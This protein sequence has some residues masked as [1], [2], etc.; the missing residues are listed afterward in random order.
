M[1]PY[2]ILLLLILLFD[3]LY[4]QPVSTLPG[5]ISPCNYSSKFT[6][7][8]SMISNPAL[9]ASY[10]AFT[11]AVYTDRP[12]MLAALEHGMLA[13][14]FPLKN[15]GLGLQL[16]YVRSGAYHQS[17][18]GIAYAKKLG[19][20][21]LGVRFNYHKLAVD[22][23]GAATAIVVDVGSI[24][25]VTDKLHAGMDLYNPVGGKLGSNGEKLPYACSAG[26]GYEVSEQVLL[27]AAI[28]KDE[29]RPANINAGIHYQPAD[30]VVVQ[31]G[32]ARGQPYLSTGLQWKPWQM[33][34]TVSYH[35]QL[36]FTPAL[37][38]IYKSSKNR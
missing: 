35:A 6:D 16:N 34:V 3:V 19:Q 2:L 32:L 24:W 36:G 28:I 20:L 9:L 27:S 8:F 31:A 10:P 15:A 13:A 11:A 37:S 1:R 21:D 5:R 30:M 4:S 18:A 14:A 17:E 33:L 38:L 12:F 26:L 29:N 7:V 22:G 23:Y 25:H